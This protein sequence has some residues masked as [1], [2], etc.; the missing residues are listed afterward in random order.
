MNKDNQLQKD[1]EALKKT[2]I[3]ISDKKYSSMPKIETTS[4]KPQKI[5]EF[6][7][8]SE[9]CYK[10]KEL[11]NVGDGDSFAYCPCNIY[12]TPKLY[13]GGCHF[14]CA[15][16]AMEDIINS[17]NGGDSNDLFDD[18]ELDNIAQEIW[19]DS[20]ERGRVFFEKYI[21]VGDDGHIPSSEYISEVIKYLGGN[22]KDYSVL[23]NENKTVKEISAE[24]FLSGGI[25]GDSNKPTKMHVP[26]ELEEAYIEVVGRRHAADRKFPSNMTRA[27]YYWLTRQENRKIDKIVIETINQYLKQNLILN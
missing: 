19:M 17:F 21:V 20:E 11:Y 26:K 24:L 22:P 1:I 18:D 13:Y 4:D 5:N 23:Y 10:G 6:V 3:D 9:F 27:E 16:A 7:S 2:G 15:C 14:E 25:N 12:G 8:V